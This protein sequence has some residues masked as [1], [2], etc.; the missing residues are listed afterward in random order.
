MPEPAPGLSVEIVLAVVLFAA[1]ALLALAGWLLLRTERARSKAL[2]ALARAEERAKAGEL[3]AAELSTAR[4]ELDRRA[5][6]AASLSSDVANAEARMA[7][8]LK[9]A[10]DAS[11]ELRALREE[12]ATVERTLERERAEARGLE[13]Q[14]DDLRLAK[15]QM[16]LE[17]AEKAGELMKSH[18]ETFK[19]QNKEQINSLLGPLKNDIMT[20]KQSLGAA[21]DKTVEQ[22][23]SLKEQIERLSQQS[24]TI[25]KEAVNLT[26]ALKGSVQLQ[27]ALGEMKLENIL[28]QSGLV[29]GADYTRQESFAG[30]DGRARTD[31]IVNLPTGGRVIIDSKVSLVDFERY[32]NADDDESRVQHLAAHTASMRTHVNR[33]QERDYAAIVGSQFDFVVLFVPIEPALWAA[34]QGDKNFALEA[35][36]RKIVIATPTTLATQLLTI[37]AS[38]RVE[39]RNRH[40]EK[41]AK[42]A[43]QLYDKFVAFV[44]DMQKIEQRLKQALG[45]YGDAYGKLNEGHVS[46]VARIQ[47]L[48]E[49]GAS[50]NKSLPAELIED[51]QSKSRAM[52]ADD[53]IEDVD[54]GPNV[55]QLKLEQ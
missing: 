5:R 29:E 30:E 48:K 36:E 13:R 32:V 46:I 10:A 47:K 44:G 23:G 43:G 45:S 18:S 20:F 39:N 26:R 3:A 28:K 40:A 1:L 2:A 50:T 12:K 25:S 51:F 21:H 34:L 35:L 31:Y 11:Q 42:G 33:L 49:L 27:G 16:R 17:F 6:Q 19:E 8:L 15:E 4:A 37:A 53:D 52:T 41:I 55:V 9:E 54:A 14:I 24:A 22:H 7:A 38:W